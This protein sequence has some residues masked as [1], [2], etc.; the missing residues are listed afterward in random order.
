MGLAPICSRSATE[1]VPFQQVQKQ[2]IMLQLEGKVAFITGAASG[3][4]KEI[5][6]EF[7]RAGA[8]IVVVDLN[9]AAADVTAA[10]IGKTGTKA[11]GI[12]VDVTDE[13]RVGTAVQ[14]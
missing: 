4:G 8:T 1:I 2:S 10:E 6:G 13:A 7:A 14:S 9:K 11:I 3:I 5:A 12:A